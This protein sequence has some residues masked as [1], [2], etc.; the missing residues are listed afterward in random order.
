MS[1]FVLILILCVGFVLAS[2][3]GIIN[4]VDLKD[5]DTFKYSQNPAGNQDLLSALINPN[6]FRLAC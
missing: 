2:R 6:R 3:K 4:S 1:G 5:L